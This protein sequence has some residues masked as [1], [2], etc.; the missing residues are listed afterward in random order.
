LSNGPGKKV[1]LAK[2]LPPTE[3]S[4]NI[5]L[6]RC[7]HQLIL[8]RNAPN[9]AYPIPDP[10]KYG[11]E[12]ERGRLRPK[13]MGQPP[14]APELMNDLICLCHGTCHIGC[15]CLEYEQ[16]CTAACV[17]E[18]LLDGGDTDCTNYFTLQAQD[19]DINGDG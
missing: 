18:G 1:V 2:K 4:F 9:G 11:F 8:W 3:D 5:N 15:V 16:P 17:C 12:M 13:L 7:I 6:L 14:A 19:G 10:T